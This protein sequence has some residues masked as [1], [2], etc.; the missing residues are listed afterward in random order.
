MREVSDRDGSARRLVVFDLD[1]TLLPNATA[2]QYIGQ[3]T[4]T[5][6]L[7]R[8]LETR[9]GHGEIDETK[10]GRIL[11]TAWN[12]HG[13]GIYED[14]YKLA[15]LATGIPETLD[16]LKSHSFHTALV[17]MAPEAFA[18]CLPGFDDVVGSNYAGG[19]ILLPEDKPNVARKIAS[20]SNCDPSAIVAIGDSHS[21]LPLFRMA[22]TAVAFNP[23]I[24]EI[25]ELADHV[26][27][28]P[29]IEPVL[30]HIIPERVYSGG[31]N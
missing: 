5:L 28:G 21:D 31:W 23:A 16:I 22:S 15:N 7:V 17:T 25:R 2:C 29:S 11:D 20:T 26:C 30:E 4:D 12:P 19:R 10:F 27:T 6:D 8:E 3:A 18:R 1:G 13:P 24:A 14:A 9:H